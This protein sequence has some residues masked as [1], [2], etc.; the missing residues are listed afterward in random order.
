MGTPTGTVTF[1]DNGVIL[2]SG[3]LSAGAASFTTTS[4]LATGSGHSI[5]ATYNSD[6]NFLGNSSTVI[7]FTVTKAG[8]STGTVTSSASTFSVFGQAVTFTTTV[9][10]AAPGAGLPTGMVTFLDGATPLGT[11][12]LSGGTASFTTTAALSV[13][14][15]NITAS[16]NG[17]ANFTTSTSAA[18]AQSVHKADTTT[19]TV[20]A[21]PAATVYGQGI[22]LSVTVGVKSPGAGTL[23]GT[24]T[25]LDGTTPLGTATLSAG[26]A[27]FTT[28]APLSVADHS[29][30]ATYNGDGNFNTSVSGSAT[31]EIVSKA[32]TTVNVTPSV[33]PAVFGQSIT[34]TATVGVQAPGAGVP[35]GNVSFTVDG[36]ATPVNVDANG[37]ATLTLTS[38]SKGTHTVSVSYSGDANFAVSNGASPLTLTVNAAGTTTTL[39]TSNTAPVF[40]DT[41]TL[42]ATVAVN[43]PGG[44]SP[45]GTVTFFDGTTQLGSAPVSGGTA[46]FTTNSL[47]AGSHVLS[48]SYSGDSNFVQSTTA[49]GVVQTV[50]QASTAMAVTA[51]K[52][53]VITGR[54]VT[55]TATVSVAAPGQGTPTGSVSFFDGTSLLGSATLSGNTAVLTTSFT[56]G[57]H[58]ITATYGGS[59]NFNLS[60]AVTPVIVNVGTLNQAFVAQVYMDLLHRPVDATG[61]MTWT[62]KIDAGTSRTTVV[63]MIESTQEY[64]NVEVNSLYLKYLRRNADQMGLANSTSM[65]ANGGTVEQVASILIG[66]TE[67]FNKFGGGTNDGWL[68]AVSQDV[69]GH[70][71]NST[72]RSAFLLLLQQFTPRDKIALIVLRGNEAETDLISTYYTL[73]LHRA[74]DAAGVA[75]WVNAVLNGGLRQE[76]VI[77]RIV[78]SDEYFSHL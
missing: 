49:P 7:A 34:L 11:A 55:F 39:K 53:V 50:R 59:A 56:A 26:T 8:T 18:F 44:G 47:S 31:H 22:T 17:D 52:S 66:S 2:G 46:T 21:A 36:T 38:L 10:P 65:L 29:I 58:T 74:A 45:T 20:N 3:T 63:S 64:R 9:T 35:S 25:F 4:P 37:Q 54:P 41:L 57:I 72:D 68:N 61:L 70:P 73:Y 67:Y 75:G 27:S 24:V 43:Q 1:L 14:S 5:V 32:S 19:G 69:L 23:T 77:A 42:T 16:Y 40:G 30:T 62:A 60:T 12:T 48:A 78:G 28:I 76:D 13:G 51:S 6:T 15:H 33:N 71:F